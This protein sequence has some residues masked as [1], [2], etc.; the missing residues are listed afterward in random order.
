MAWTMLSVSLAIAWAT[1]TVR[2][3]IMRLAAPPRAKARPSRISSVMS[4]LSSGARGTV[5]RVLTAV[6]PL[7][8]AA[9]VV[10]SFLLYGTPDDQTTAIAILLTLV[11]LGAQ[12][13]LLTGIA[14]AT[15]AAAGHAIWT[16]SALSPATVAAAGAG[17]L[18]AVTVASS[19]RRATRSDMALAASNERLRRLALRDPVTGLLDRRGFEQAVRIELARGSRRPAPVAF[20]VV[21]FD[22][23]N[24]DNARLGRA[25]GDTALQVLAGSL[26]RHTRATDAAARIDGDEFA[27]MLPLTERAGAEYV[28][29]R[30]VSTYVRELDAVVANMA[31]PVTVGIAVYPDDGRSVDELL[32]S[33]H[34]DLARRRAAGTD[35]R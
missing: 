31:A 2:G 10:L 35:A 6:A 22:H 15:I 26:E 5:V 23:L 13:S 24:A 18:I 8:A 20:V 16:G 12:R 1:R 11:S 27:L 34:A 14:A 33:A 4:A 19:A 29:G 3:D 21:D 30:I 28:S 25:V 7:V 32:G 9:L 17:L